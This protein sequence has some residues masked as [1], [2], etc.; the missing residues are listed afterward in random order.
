METATTIQ[1]DKIKFKPEFMVRFES[2]S[3]ENGINL[4]MVVRYR[5]TLSQ[6]PKPTVWI[7]PETSETYLLS[8]RNRLEASRLEG[9]NAVE[10]KYFQGS[11]D[12]AKVYARIANL[13]HGLP[14]TRKEW[15]QA[16]RDIVR[17]RHCR[18]NAWIAREAQCSS[19][20]IAKYRA[21]LEK[22]GEIPWH[23]E[24]KAEN[25]EMILRPP[26]EETELMDDESEG[27]TIL[28]TPLFENDIEI[29]AGKAQYGKGMSAGRKLGGEGRQGGA[30][31]GPGN[32]QP[33][34]NGSNKVTLKLNR[35]GESLPGEVIMLINGQRY[36]IQVTILIS[37]DPVKGL[38]ETV[39]G[40]NNCLIIGEALIKGLK[41]V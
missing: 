4:D 21:E 23:R 19:P 22:T 37:R 13:I 8:G 40:H 31:A 38:S 39:P 35:V 36:S 2:A 3:K 20:T 9:Y 30:D 5:E 18:T 10:V 24:L 34:R 29:Q 17:I 32:G 11:F 26:L 1:I 28:P 15:Q 33:P 27:T 14:F 12:D 16:I 25:G 7:D 6:L 41:F